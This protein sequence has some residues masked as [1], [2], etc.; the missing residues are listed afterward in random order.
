MCEL[1]KK[2]INLH[3][4]KCFECEASVMSF[5]YNTLIEFSDY[6]GSV[7]LH[8]YDSVAEKLLAISAMRFKELK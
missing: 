6:S 8:V 2:K 7:M 5:K 4:Q 1:C 3:S